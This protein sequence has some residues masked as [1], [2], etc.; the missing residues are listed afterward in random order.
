[1]RRTVPG[2]A[3]L[4][5]NV[6]ALVAFV[7]LTSHW[8]ADGELA[9]TTSARGLAA[10]LNAASTLPILLLSEV[11]R[12]LILAFAGVV[13][14]VALL[15]ALWLRKWI[16]SAIVGAT[17]AAWVLTALVSGVRLFG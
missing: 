1:M 9:R 10:Y 16:G 4:T 3:W 13:H 7:V 17:L 11:G 14:L 2:A 12:L 8:L 5:G 15:R 6:I